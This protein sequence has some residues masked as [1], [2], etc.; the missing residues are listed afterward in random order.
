MSAAILTVLVRADKNCGLEA[1]AP[2][3]R[4]HNSVRNLDRH[5]GNVGL[6]FV[7]VKEKMKKTF[8]YVSFGSVAI[9]AS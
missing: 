9:L 7:D 8:H 4:R 3:C 6:G 2:R 1:R 5:G